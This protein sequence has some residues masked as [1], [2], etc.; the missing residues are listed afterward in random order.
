MLSQ[1]FED[2]SSQPDFKLNF[3]LR[4]NELNCSG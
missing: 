3:D 1:N 2:R 4:N